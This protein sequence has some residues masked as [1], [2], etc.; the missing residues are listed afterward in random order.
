MTSL[1]KTR[2]PQAKIVFLSSD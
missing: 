2:S 1:T